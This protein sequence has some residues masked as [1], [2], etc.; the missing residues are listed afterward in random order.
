MARPL[1]VR[2]IPQFR[3]YLCGAA[4]AQMIL[5]FRGEQPPAPGMTDEEWQLAIW[6]DIESETTG[7]NRRPE[8]SSSPGYIPEFKRQQCVRCSGGNWNCWATTPQALAAALA[9]RLSK[10]THHL[11]V[12]RV[13]DSHEPPMEAVLESIDNGAP[14]AAL[15]DSGDH[16]LVIKGYKAGRNTAETVPIFDRLLNGVWVCDPGDPLSR[17][18]ITAEEFVFQRFGPTACG[19]Q[20][21]QDRFVVLAD[22]TAI[23]EGRMVDARPTEPELQPLLTPAAA[24]SAAERLAK[25]LLEDD[26]DEPEWVDALSNARPGDPQLVQRLDRVDDY[27]YV[28]PLVREGQITARLALDAKTGHLKEVGGIGEPGQALQPLTPWQTPADFLSRVAGQLLPLSTIK[29]VVRPE[30]VGIHPQFVWRPCPQS[31]SPLIPFSLLT[32][33]DVQIYLRVD[34]KT[35]PNLTPV[36]SG[37]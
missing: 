24:V 35:F 1:N 9:A 10:A 8:S 17:R 13:A 28:V 26:S 18:M 19:L 23:R 37:R 30:T 7:S 36:G 12:L 33:A 14:A 31:R 15:V 21:D 6:S 29:R 11:K 34:G 4:V 5:A 22:R 32:I 16:W 2:H 20:A 25:E 3:D 27:Y